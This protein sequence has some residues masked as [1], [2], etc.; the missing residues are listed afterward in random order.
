MDTNTI[1]EVKR[2]LGLAE[3]VLTN[4]AKGGNVSLRST[5][6]L[7][8]FVKIAELPPCSVLLALRSRRYRL[9]HRQPEPK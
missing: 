3:D 4:I 8:A 5:D 7:N 9:L 6:W 1:D 2:E